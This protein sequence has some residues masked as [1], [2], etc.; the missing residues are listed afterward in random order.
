MARNR[1]LFID[2]QVFQSAAWDRGMGKYSLAL[3]RA[4][5]NETEY[6]YQQTYIIFTKNIPLIPEAIKQIKRAAP[7][8]EHLVVDLKVPYDPSLENIPSMQQSNE[9]IL[10]QV[11]S[12][13]TGNS[14]D[15][16]YMILALFVDQVCSVYPTVAKERLLLF[17]DLIP[18][19]YS[20]RYGLLASYKNYLARFKVLFE[21][22]KILTISQTVADDVMLNLG[23]SKAKL[24]NI[25][26][27]P[28]HRDTHYAHKPKGLTKGKFLLMPS[29]N[30]IRKNNVRAVQ[31]FE[32]YCQEAGI[33]DM[34]LILTSH[35]DSE[36]QTQLQA[37][38]EHIKFT[39]NVSEAELRWLYENSEALLFMPEYEGL[40][41]PILEATEVDKPI[42]CSD[43]TVFNEISPEAFYYADQYDAQS[44]A[45]AIGNALEQK[46]FEDKQK[47]YP[48]ILERYTWKATAKKSI[49]AFEA[50]VQYANISKKLKLA[51]MSP[52]PGGYSA[53]G[54]FTLQLHSSLC[55]FFDVDYFI[56]SGKTH[57]EFKRPDYLQ[58]IANVMSASK[59]NHKSYAEYD[60]VLYHIGNS[61]FH[62]ETIKDALHLPGFTIFHDTYLSNVF[63]GELLAYNYIT[64]D[65]LEAEKM[66]DK[67]I[68]NKR[69][70]Y[71]SSVVNNQLGLIAHS[72]YALE[73]IKLS[74]V[75]QEKPAI[76]LN[77]PVVVPKLS[78]QKLDNHAVT[79][80]LAGIIHPAKG[81][82][83]IEEIARS[84]ASPNLIIRVFGLSLV[85]EDVIRRLRS[86]PNV[87]VDTDIPDF[88]FQNILRQLDVLVNF[89]PDY[90][91]ETSLATLE[92]M[93]FGVVPVVRK[94]GWY[95][96][97][98]D[99]VALKV[100]SQSEV[101]GAIQELV[102]D[103]P[104]LDRMKQNCK[105]FISE[106]HSYELY[107][108]GLYDLVKSG[109]STDV[110]RA[111]RRNASL[112]EI[113]DI[114]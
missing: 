60:A 75:D 112:K 111:L 89:R 19:Q 72:D 108:Q 114:L 55:E 28:I 90:R 106:N 34:S 95:D 109:I 30:D 21:A 18:L 50:S 15:A 83:L 40:G 45:S 58:Y 16:S 51:V 37:C 17:Y 56:E 10:D 46:D 61:E 94:V 57:T 65:R 102:S 25:D 26:G 5:V 68:G 39:G 52:T 31:G 78:A 82:D 84:Q 8:A 79:L 87:Y 113:I 20:E 69:V 29:G 67:K 7:K 74:E 98:P 101:I 105:T 64:Q 14:S 99:T 2:G 73:S 97:L 11:V 107:A 41:L 85:G 36:T 66:L 9:E 110:S 44:I 91:G 71:I 54:K 63:E 103:H 100:K 48:G 33:S 70:S 12:S 6:P 62:L 27:A 76:K 23:I 47:K 24:F 35:F 13:N 53:I 43:L 3:L 49:R 92:A 88:Q 38:S 96:E 22:D 81:L 32:L 86:Y 59:F 93:R 104:R 1:T 4:L 42:V 77:L 80:G